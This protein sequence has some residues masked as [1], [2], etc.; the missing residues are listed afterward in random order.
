MLRQNRVDLLKSG[1][2][3]NGHV[4]DIYLNWK[5]VDTLDNKKEAV[6]A[7]KGIAHQHGASLHMTV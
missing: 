7:A 1:G 6:D 4:Y 5:N 3:I 2:P